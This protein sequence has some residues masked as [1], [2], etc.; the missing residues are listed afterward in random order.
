MRDGRAVA[1]VLIAAVMW[2]TT[3]TARALAPA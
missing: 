1:M 3:G 2:G